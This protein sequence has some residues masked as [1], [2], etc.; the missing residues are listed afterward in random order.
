M[1]VM[2][3]ARV[4]MPAVS[5]AKKEKKPMDIASAVKGYGVYAQPN[6]QS[7]GGPGKRMLTALALLVVVGSG[8]PHILAAA[9]LI[10]AFSKSWG[11]LQ[12]SRYISRE[13]IPSIKAA[14]DPAEAMDE[15]RQALPGLEPAVQERL[16]ERLEKNGFSL[17]DIPA[18]AAR[19]ARNSLRHFW[20]L[21]AGL[22]FFATSTIVLWAA[23]MHTHI[24]G[25]MGLDEG[26]DWP[27]YRAVRASIA[28]TIVVLLPISKLVGIVEQKL[29]LNALFAKVK[30]DEDKPALRQAIKEQDL[31]PRAMNRAIKRYERTFNERWS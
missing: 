19:F 29:S 1:S 22:K 18:A 27:L 31:A 4:A 7:L 9:I 3:T 25:A 8:T 13:V 24:A 28:L 5:V 21:G 20:S 2:S 23:T 12:E 17:L 6:F 26:T 10:F 16:V 15:V 14:E 11:R 30:T